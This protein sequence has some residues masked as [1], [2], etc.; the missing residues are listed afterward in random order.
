[1]SIENVRKIIEEMKRKKLDVEECLVKTSTPNPCATEEMILSAEK[2][3]GI[4]FPESYKTFL[5]EYGNG[6][7]YLFGAEPLMGVGDKLVDS[8]TTTKNSLSVLMQKEHGKDCYLFPE[9]R[10]ISLCQLVP[11]TYGD[12]LE[13]SNDHWAFL[14]DK[15]Y[16]NHDY[17]VVY[18]SQHSEDVICKLDNFE[19]WLEIFW[20]GNKD[21][22][23]E[24]LYLPTFYF[25]YTDWQ[26][27]MDL[28]DADRSELM[29][30]Y[31]RIRMENDANFKKYGVNG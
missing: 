4:I 8:L 10:M 27:R 17:P 21:R 7:F 2:N 28:I 18:V 11:F 6:D 9:N 23:A 13:I 25:L 16:P 26:G 14:C 15:E 19:K 5:K 29:E 1:M 30:I 22:K 12:S 31:D 24:D 20:I 3:C